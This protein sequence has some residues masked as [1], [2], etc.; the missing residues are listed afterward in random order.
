[1]SVCRVELSFT[2]A[3]ETLVDQ[4]RIGVERVGG[5]FVGSVSEGSFHLPTS[6]GD[7]KGYYRVS[8]KVLLLEVT[9]KPFLVPCR[10][11]QRKLRDYVRSRW[12]S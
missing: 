3:R 7:F 8:E 4:I 2:V 10:V 6:V 5:S 9:D 1:M 11:I 12:T